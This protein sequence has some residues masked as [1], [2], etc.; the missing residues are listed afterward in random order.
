VIERPASVVKELVENSIDAGSSRITIDIRQGGRELIQVAD[1]GIGMSREEILLALERHATSKIR[2]FEDL[3]EV[4]SLGF[5]GEALPSIAAVSRMEIVSRPEEEGEAARVVVHGGKVIDSAET[6]RSSGTTVTVKDLFYNTPVRRKFLK[7]KGTELRKILQVVTEVGLTNLAVSIIL[8]H[9]GKEILECEATDDLLGRVAYLFSDE[10]ARRML[11]VSDHREGMEIF[12]LISR[13]ED[14]GG[15]KALEYAFVNGRPVHSPL[16]RNALRKSYRATLRAGLQADYFL[17]L[18]IRPS[19]V[20]VNIHPTKREVKFREEEKVVELIASAV[21]RTLSSPVS[22]PSYQRTGSSNGV[23]ASPRARYLPAEG[24]SGVAREEADQMAFLFTGPGVRGGVDGEASGARRER[25][26][27]EVYYPSIVQIHNTFLIVQT[28]HGILI[29]DQHASHERVL[30]EKLIDSFTRG[31]LSAQRLLFPLT[32]HL[33]PVQYATVMD[34]LSFFRDFGFDI[35]PF[36]GKSVILHSVPSLHDRF[37]VERAFREM[38]DELT[39]SAQLRMKHHE[40]M[41]KVIACKAALKA[42]QS[43]SRQEM[44]ELFDTLFATRVP[45]RDIHGRPT[46]VQIGIDELRKRFERG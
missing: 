9:D 17:F 22:I 43:L 35:E 26:D 27:E 7:S 13:P 1:N 6:S 33:N 32:F 19:D 41:A 39:E 10:V 42:G 21:G 18:V 25:L 14:A 16:V 5:R 2:S 4:T 23:G 3:Q 30:Y 11:P 46:M 24:V 15:G 34:H 12:G 37:E 31:N 20:D 40:Q 28:R 29:L 38:I 45:S 36:G 44:C 8:R